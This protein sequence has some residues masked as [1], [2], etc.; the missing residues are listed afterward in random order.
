MD[1]EQLKYFRMNFWRDVVISSMEAE[2]A[3]PV[4]FADE[5][6]FS[7]DARFNSGEDEL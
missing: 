7:F 2:I 6:L 3:E 1:K 4:K 5:V